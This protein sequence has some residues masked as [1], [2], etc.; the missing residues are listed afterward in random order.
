MNLHQEFQERNQVANPK[1][2]K[3]RVRP[4]HPDLSVAFI[5]GL[6]SW[7]EEA[8]TAPAVG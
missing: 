8:R 7:A 1:R 2:I 6:I 5:P 4:S 3:V